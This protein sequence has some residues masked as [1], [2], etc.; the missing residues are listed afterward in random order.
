MDNGPSVFADLEIGFGGESGP[1]VKTATHSHHHNDTHA[2]NTGWVTVHVLPTDWRVWAVV[3][4]GAV[5]I[6]VISAI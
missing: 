4:V 1:D 3:T 6:A 5:A 2:W